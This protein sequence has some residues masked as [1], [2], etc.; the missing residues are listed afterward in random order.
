MFKGKLAFKQYNPARRSRFGIKT[1]VL[2]DCKTGF[3][4]DVLPYAGKQSQ[5]EVNK[6]L[7][8]SGAIVEKLMVPY[9]GKQH[10]LYMDNWFSSP[11]LLDY[12]ARKDTGVIGTVKRNWKHYP[13]FLATKKARQL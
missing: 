13:Q 5:L 12:L 1:F 6:D 7:G 8:A 3:V 4:L 2:C 9:T 11:T 10:L